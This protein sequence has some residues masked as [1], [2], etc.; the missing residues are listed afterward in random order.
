MLQASEANDPLASKILTQAG[1]E[2]AELARIISKHLFGKSQ[3]V[4]VAMSGGV[5]RNSKLVRETFMGN[6]SSFA[7]IALNVVDPVDGALA[8]AR[9]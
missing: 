2:L 7:T 1:K 8:L 5:F 3:A 4:P 9:K 6:L